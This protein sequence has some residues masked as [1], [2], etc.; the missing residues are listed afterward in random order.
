MSLVFDW[1]DS[2]VVDVECVAKETQREFGLKALVFNDEEPAM[3]HDPVPFGFNLPVLHID[4]SDYETE[5][6]VI[7]FVEER[8]GVFLGT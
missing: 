1:E 8:G 4:R 7:A 6:R 5:G 2:S 3:L